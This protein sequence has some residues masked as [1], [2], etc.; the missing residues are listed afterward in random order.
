MRRAVLPT[1]PS[2]GCHRPT[3]PRVAVALLLSLLSLAVAAVVAAGT[4]IA[5]WSDIPKKNGRIRSPPSP[6]FCGQVEL[7]QIPC[8]DLEVEGQTTT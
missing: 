2:A 8:P 6:R 3:P 7:F 1:L 4:P 5:R